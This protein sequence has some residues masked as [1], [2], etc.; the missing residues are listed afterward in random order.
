MAYREL[1]G[2]YIKQLNEANQRIFELEAAVAECE[3]RL[4]ATN[5]ASGHYNTEVSTETHELC[6]K[7][8]SANSRV[9]D[10]ERQLANSRENGIDAD[11]A[12]L[13][14]QLNEATMRNDELQTDL[15]LQA[16]LSTTL[17]QNVSVS[18]P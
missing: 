4:E 14:R 18:S 17:E 5:V 6:N 16:G 11:T 15:V 8:N 3:S 2:K 1:T 10:L 9:S 13:T 12:A 7:L